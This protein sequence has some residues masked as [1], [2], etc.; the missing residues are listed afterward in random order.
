MVAQRA[1]DDATVT[2]VERILESE[3]S[4]AD[5]IAS[6]FDRAL[7]ASLAAQGIAA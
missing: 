7:D 1:G 6:H 5:R 2:T 4:T 3:R